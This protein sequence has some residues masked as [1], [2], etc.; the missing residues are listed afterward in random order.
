M[1]KPF[2]HLPRSGQIGIALGGVAFLVFGAAGGCGA[3]KR[4]PP[5]TAEERA[6]LQTAPLPYS[7]TVAWWDEETKTGKSDEAYAGG[8][9][10]VVAASGAFR[11]FRY[12]RSSSPSNQDLVATSTG[13]YCNTAVIPIFSI[14]SLGVIPTIFQD[15]QCKGML[16]RTA[17]GRPKRE[18]VVVEVRYKGPVVMGWAAVVI[19]A[20]PGWSYG[21]ADTDPR[22]VERFRLAVISRR[23]E[24]ERLVGR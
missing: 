4:P 11:A 8:L 16:L 1:L 2:N 10:E 21:S 12:E 7:V 5:L 9:A 6:L 18:G 22:F 19:G 14:I 3:Y 23:G 17:A 13:L 24:I 20:L 15:Q